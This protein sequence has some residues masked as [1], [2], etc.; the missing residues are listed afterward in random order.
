MNIEPKEAFPYKPP[1]EEIKE[2]YSYIFDL[3]Q[4]LPQRFLKTIF[5]KFVSIIFLLCAAPILVLLKICFLIEGI[6][7]SENKGPMFFYYNAVSN[8]KEFKKYKIRIIKMKYIDPEGAKKGDWIAYSAEWNDESKT[9]IGT[10]VKNFYLDEI[11]QFFSVLKGEMSIVGPR[12]LSVLHTERDL[13]QGNVTR[14]LIKGGLLGLGHINKGTSEMGNPIY[15]YEYI[16]KYMNASDIELLLLDL[17]IIY[18]GILLIFKGE[19]Y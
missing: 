18:K 12:P 17:K 7:I 15:E 9:N 14:K 6:L 2:K 3:D 10:I 11:P 16:D 19:G 8:G 5:D 13:Q 4:P 1:S